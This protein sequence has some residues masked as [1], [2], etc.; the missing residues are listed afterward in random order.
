MYQFHKNYSLSI[1]CVQ[2]DGEQKPSSHHL[3]LF[4]YFQNEVNGFH[5]VG[6]WVAQFVFS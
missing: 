6:Q 3:A 1:Y 5:L 2:G 4:I